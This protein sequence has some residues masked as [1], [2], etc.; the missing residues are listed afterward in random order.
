MAHL[1]F[2]RLLLLNAWEYRAAIRGG[3]TPGHE[4]ALCQV[5]TQWLEAS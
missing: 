4:E 2:D 5:S 3:D 1:M